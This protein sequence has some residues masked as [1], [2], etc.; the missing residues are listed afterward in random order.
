M[1]YNGKLTA[2]FNGIDKNQKVNINGHKIRRS[3]MITKRSTI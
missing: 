1:I 3:I 2:I